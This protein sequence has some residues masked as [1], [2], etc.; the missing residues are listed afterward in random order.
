MKQ[1]EKLTTRAGKVAGLQRV[2]KVLE[3]VLGGKD[4]I[5]RYPSSPARTTC[6]RP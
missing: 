4:V 5:K 1:N 3:R 6:R 2:D